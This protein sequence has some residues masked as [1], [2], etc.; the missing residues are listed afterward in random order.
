MINDPLPDA[1]R[2]FAFHVPNRRHAASTMDP[3]TTTTD[4]RSP[5][6]E[7]PGGECLVGQSPLWREL[8]GQIDRAARAPVP[9]LI[10]GEVGTEIESVGWAVAEA[11]AAEQGEQLDWRDQG[12]LN[13]A[14]LTEDQL[15]ERLFDQP[16]API[17]MIDEVHALS[18]RLQARLLE[19]L[20]FEQTQSPATRWI[21]ASRQDLGQEIQEGRFREDLYWSLSVLPI[22][23][24]PLRRRREDI[25][26]LVEFW[27]SHD[28]DLLALPIP[29]VDPGFLKAL[30][31]YAFPGNIRQLRNYLQRSLVQ[32]DDRLTEDL[33]PASML[34]D[35]EQAGAAVFRPVDDASLIREFVA[36][37]LQQT[38]DE[39]T[40]LYRDVLKPVEKELFQQVLQRC[41][42]TQTKA[43]R[44][45]GINRNTLYQKLVDFGLIKPKSKD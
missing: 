25:P 38:A 11:I 42:Q 27:L 32:A 33:L 10:Q 23:V 45:L 34:G 5:G 17:Q 35:R 13:A 20:Q 9:V 3:L 40:E 28:A 4:N 36:N 1:P 44:L 31:E 41:G 19:R 30:Q 24:P 43:A 7:Y 12:Y 15:E 21:A 16:A 39:H 6:L 22:E 8:L 2:S 37:Q 14:A 29:E 26:Q 18:P